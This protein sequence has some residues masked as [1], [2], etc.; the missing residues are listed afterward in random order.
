MSPT[1]IDPENPLDKDELVVHEIGS[2]AKPEW[3]VKP[4][5]GD[6]VS[7]TDVQDARDWA[8]K[9]GIT[10]EAQ[11]LFDL[12]ADKRHGFTDAE[13]ELITSQASLFAIRLQEHAGMDWVYD[14]EQHRSEM[15]RYPVTHS[16]GFEFRGYC[17]SFD[18][19]YWNKAAVVDQPTIDQPFHTNEFDTISEHAQAPVKVP[20]TGAYTLVDWSFDEHYLRRR[21]EA[22]DVEPGTPKHAE[23]RAAARREFAIDVARRIVR[24]NIE[25][26]V[27]RGARWIQIDEPAVTTH[28]DEVDIYVEA[29]NEATKGFEDVRFATHI[30]FSDYTELFPDVLELENCHEFSLELA[31]RD[32]DVP[33]TDRDTRT[34]YHMLDAF[35]E[36]DVDQAIGL[37]V[38]DI[39]TDEIEDPEVVADRIRYA[40]DVFDDDPSKVWPCTDCGLRTRDWETSHQKMQRV[41]EG[42]QRVR[43]ELGLD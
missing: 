25:A 41:A 35:A 14:G 42:A 37:G 2:L 34:G 40:L 8:T 3:R 1:T 11:P 43:K 32:P 4:K 28:P 39:H 23:A 27:D 19:K 7:D 30:C 38:V 17:R 10:N 6:P 26:L 20:I 22:E 31:N 33:G 18:N 16:E 12:F 21:L 5:R 29:F 24:P 13:R 36:H 9:L 15:Y